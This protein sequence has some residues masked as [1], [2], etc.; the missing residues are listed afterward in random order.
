MSVFIILDLAK[1]RKLL[2][3]FWEKAVGTKMILKDHLG[4]LSCWK[5]WETFTQ[6]LP[7]SSRL[8]PNER[9]LKRPY[10][11]AEFYKQT[12][13]VF[14]FVFFFLWGGGLHP[15]LLLSVKINYKIKVK[16]RIIASSDC[17]LS[18]W[19]WFICFYVGK[20]RFHSTL[21]I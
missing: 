17:Y 4:F 9:H 21:N 8:K 7:H 15:L 16:L 13:L 3:S 12:C 20:L 5:M 10:C 2:L 1:K 18:F 6:M 19:L 11:M 14:F